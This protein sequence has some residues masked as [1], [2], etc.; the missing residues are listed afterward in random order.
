MVD[1]T[2]VAEGEEINITLAAA[3]GMVAKCSNSSKMINITKEADEEEVV[4]VAGTT[5]A[6]I[7]AMVTSTKPDITI[8][9]EGEDIGEV[10]VRSIHSDNRQ[11]FSLY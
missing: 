4:A 10:E 6:T 2:V 5:R 8:V 9:A 3:V 7:R 11:F 1:I